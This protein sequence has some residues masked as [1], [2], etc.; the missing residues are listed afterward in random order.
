MVSARFEIPMLGFLN[1]TKN[2]V[3]GEEHLTE[4]VTAILTATDDQGPRFRCNFVATQ[5]SREVMSFN[6]P[7][8]LLEIE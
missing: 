3:L 1:L 7:E 2:N 4:A 5:K 8:E 6:N